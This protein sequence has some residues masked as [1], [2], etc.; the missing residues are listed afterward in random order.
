MISHE[1]FMACWPRLCVRWG[2]T[3]GREEAA[4]YYRFLSAR[5]DTEEFE[6]AAEM[7]WATREFFPKPADFVAAGPITEWPDVLK[8]CEGGPAGEEAFHGLSICAQE[9]FRAV[10]SRVAAQG[11]RLGDYYPTSRLTT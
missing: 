4:L 9:A 7:L 11:A 1:V 10:G 6:I 3:V 5:M 8:V 2:R